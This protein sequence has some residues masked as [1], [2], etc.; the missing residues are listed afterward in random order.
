MNVY[1]NF[2]HNSTLL[3][4]HSAEEQTTNDALLLVMFDRHEEKETAEKVNLI[5]PGSELFTRTSL[6]SPALLA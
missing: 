4:V 1:N 3:S 5:L 6:L 2:N